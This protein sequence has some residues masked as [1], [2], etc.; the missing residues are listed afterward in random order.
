ML[1]PGEEG[2]RGPPHQAPPPGWSSRR[3]C[4]SPGT[5]Q[6]G[7]G[8]CLSVLP[9]R[10]RR[11]RSRSWQPCRAPHH[12]RGLPRIRS[13]LARLCLPEGWVAGAASVK[14]ECSHQAP[15]GPPAAS[16]IRTAAGAA[17][18]NLISAPNKLLCLQDPLPLPISG[19]DRTADGCSGHTPD[20]KHHPDPAWAHPPASLSQHQGRRARSRDPSMPPLA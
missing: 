18:W 1:G 17:A 10:K 3:V 9:M 6:P 8:R 19:N 7:D 2:G 11:L 5:R 15:W 12:C 13:I 20:A 14:P 16:S 4:N